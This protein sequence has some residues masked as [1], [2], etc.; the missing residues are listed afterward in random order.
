MEKLEYI[1][2]RVENTKDSY[3]AIAKDFNTSHTQIG[4]YVKNNGWNV[5]HRVSKVST[6]TPAHNAI[7][8]KTA[9]RKIQEIKDELASNYSPVDEPLIVMYAKSYERYIALETKMGND[10][11]GIIAIS[12]KTGTEYLSPLFTAAL[13]IQKNLV[14][15]ANQLGLSIA[16]RKKLNLKIGKVD[17]KGQTSIFDFAKDLTMKDDD[18]N[19]I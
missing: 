6:T 8:G 19:D 7:L 15:I 1:K 3:R 2:D 9:L 5:S 16:S 14:T 17:T 11:S 10:V 13:A 18:L 12:S 4:N